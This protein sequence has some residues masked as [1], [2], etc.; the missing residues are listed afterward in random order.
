MRRGLNKVI[1]VMKDTKTKGNTQSSR[2]LFVDN[3]RVLLT[4]LVVAHHAGQ[5]YGPTGG[6]WLIFNPERAD[7]LVVCQE[8]IE[9]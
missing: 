2:L 5:P 9:G 7:I 3:L 6:M 4:I 1:S 8:I